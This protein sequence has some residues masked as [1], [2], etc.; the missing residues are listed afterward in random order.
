LTKGRLT[1]GLIGDSTKVVL[2]VSSCF[3]LPE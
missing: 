3:F 1:T 2:I